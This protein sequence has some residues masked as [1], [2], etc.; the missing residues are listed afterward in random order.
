MQ[1]T[2]HLRRPRSYRPRL[3]RLEER[4]VPTI[5]TVTTLLDNVA[6]SLRAEV[7]PAQDGDRIQFADGLGGQIT[8]TTGEIALNH[9]IRIEGP[10]LDVIQVSGNHNGRIFNVAANQTVSISGLTIKDGALTGQG[11]GGGILNDGMLTVTESALSDNAAPDAGGGIYNTGVLT[12]DR[13]ALSGN[14]ARNVGGALFNSGGTVAITNCT[15]SGNTAGYQAGG[16]DNVGGPLT[17]TDSTVSGNSALDGAGVVNT[18]FGGTLTFTRCTVSGNTAGREGGGILNGAT[19]RVTDSGVRDNTAL[20]GAG[21]YNASGTSVAVTG[22]TFSGNRATRDGG[23]LMSVGRNVSVLNSTFSDNVAGGQGGGVYNFYLNSLLTL[24]D[25]TVSGNAAGG[26]GGGVA[27]ATGPET[28]VRNSLIAGNSAGS[29]PDVVRALR[30]LGHNLIG[31][32]TGGSGYADTDLVGTAANPIDP[33][34]GPLQDNGG[35][36]KTMALLPGSPALNAGDPAELG[37]PDQRG[38]VRGGGVNVGAYQATASAFVVTALD[39]VPPGK[40]LTW[41]SRP[42]TCSAKWRSATPARST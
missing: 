41:W 34:L 7:L 4:D 40:R 1:S 19:L 25:S 39:T 5:L 32:G 29:S 38:V 17:I 28:D 13:S 22:S 21:V 8:L 36:T 2:P 26:Q 37:T 6:G 15:I 42:W 18:N 12:L 27:T 16:I 3:E 20:D 31:D 24:A 33:R 35:S 14:D 10:G 30:S 9:S 11:D 23:G